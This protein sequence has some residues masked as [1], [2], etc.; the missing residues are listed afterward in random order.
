V[1]EERTERDL[2]R[3]M[4]EL[5]EAK[6]F[7]HK[8]LAARINDTLKKW[9]ESALREQGKDM[10]SAWRL[11]DEVLERVSVSPETVERWEKVGF[12]VQRGTRAAHELYSSPAFLA[13]GKVL[14]AG[15]DDMDKE[16][17]NRTLQPGDSVV[18]PIADEG[19][20]S[21]REN[22][23]GEAEFLVVPDGFGGTFLKEMQDVT[24][25]DYKAIKT[26]LEEEAAF[27]EAESEKR[28]DNFVREQ[29]INMD[30]EIESL[31]EEDEPGA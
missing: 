11:R 2:G 10:R 26:Y 24:D 21:L 17:S 28:I 18:R 6:G 30:Q 20:A 22:A 7:T 1:G 13:L 29:T 12:G 5:R 19:R 15:P 3:T 27:V 4:K 8:D 9:L 14:D 31:L 16:I 25:A 23:T